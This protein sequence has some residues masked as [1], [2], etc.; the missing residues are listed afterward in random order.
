MTQL[1][2]I[3]VSLHFGGV[4]AVSEVS[5]KVRQGASSRRNTSGVTAIS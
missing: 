3:D 5:M 4:I 2:V 1:D